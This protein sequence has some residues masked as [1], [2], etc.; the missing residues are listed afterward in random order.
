[1]ISQASMVNKL[2]SNVDNASQMYLE[3]SKPVVKPVAFQ[4]NIPWRQMRIDIDETF[5]YNENKSFRFKLPR[6]GLIDPRSIRLSFNCK[7]RADQGEAKISTTTAHRAS[8]SFDINS[9]FSKVSLQVGRGRVLCEQ[10]AYNWISRF[11]SKVFVEPQTNLSHRALLEGTGQTAAI[12]DNAPGAKLNYHANLPSIQK[13]LSMEVPRRYITPIQLGIFMQKRPII[14]DPFSEQ[15]ELEFTIDRGD[16]A[17]FHDQTPTTTIGKYFVEVGY[18]SLLFTYFPLDNMPLY[19]PIKK[20]LQSPGFSYQYLQW[21]YNTF[22]MTSKQ[23][24]QLFTIPIFKKYIRHAIAFISCNDDLDSQAFSSFRVYNTLEPTSSYSFTFST[25]AAAQLERS[26]IKKA[27]IKQYQWLYNK[28]IRIPD[29]PIGVTNFRSFPLYDTTTGTVVPSG[30]EGSGATQSA[31]RQTISD[32]HI[33]NGEEAWYHIEQTLLKDKEEKM[34]LSHVVTEGIFMPIMANSDFYGCQT[35][36]EEGNISTSKYLGSGGLVLG[37]VC[38]NF[39]MVGQFSYPLYDGTIGCLSGGSNNETLQ[40]EIELNGV[41]SDTPN[42][43]PSMQLNVFVAY[44][45]IVNVTEDSVDI[46]Q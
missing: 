20:Q 24:K 27:S 6:S 30:S 14:L 37:R 41:V 34:A 43:S 32:K 29:Q 17:P 45:N 39:F 40:L 38:S 22:P 19:Y 12:G 23:Q 21:D 31:I 36:G 7:C 5:T 18:P 26:N 2:A 9:I 11:L 1:M 3:F 4:N 13:N 8:F 42:P 44:D 46:E 10:N 16:I 35:N 28:H 15:L 25:T 33:N